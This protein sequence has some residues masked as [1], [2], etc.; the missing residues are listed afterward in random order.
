MSV[1]SEVP[2]NQANAFSFLIPV[3]GLSMGV[4]FYGETLGLL[5]LLGIILA[6][7]GVVLVTRKG[8]AQEANVPASF[9][10][11]PN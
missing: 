6:I 2:L 5:K 4:L 11:A 7:I 3:F 1:L 10:I 9:K 8:A